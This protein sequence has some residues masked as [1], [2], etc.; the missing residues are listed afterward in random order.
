MVV[1]AQEQGLEV[2]VSDLFHIQLVF[3]FVGEGF[4]EFRGDDMFAVEGGARRPRQTLVGV[5]VARAEVAQQVVV[6]GTTPRSLL[7]WLCRVF[8]G[9]GLCL[10]LLNSIECTS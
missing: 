6:H 4:G 10:R 3:K 5:E 8:G 1:R 9:L 2:N 7:H